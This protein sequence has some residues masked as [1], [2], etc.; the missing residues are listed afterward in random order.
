VDALLE[1]EGI[2]A[3]TFAF[4]N[5]PFYG[6]LYQVME[7]YPYD[8]R[9]TEEL[10]RQAGLTKGADGFYTSVADGRFSPEVLGVA[11]GIEGLEATAAADYFRRAGIDAQLRLLPSSVLSRDNELKSVYPAF[12]GNQAMLPERITTGG[13]ATAENRWSGVNKTGYSDPE[14]DRLYELWTK[15][16]DKIERDQL[17]I[18]M[19]KGMNDNL[20]G[21]PLYYNYWV[22]AHLA[23]L[24]GP[25][26][27]I[28]QYRSQARIYSNIH[29]WRWAR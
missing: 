27:R 24:E 26:P 12:R 2:V 16:L 9:R 28:P 15:T 8:L 10:M 20:P 13:I 4:P 19:Y 25:L 14:H 29:Q 7:K 22:I 17:Q 6:T 23:E 1:G 18:Q 3:E 11:E 21:L 5:E